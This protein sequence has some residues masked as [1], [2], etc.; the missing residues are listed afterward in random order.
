MRKGVSKSF[1]VLTVTAIALILGNI[2]TT[3]MPIVYA[4]EIEEINQTDNPIDT[5]ETDV[6]TSTDSDESDSNTNNSGNNDSS[7][8]DD[9]L[10]VNSSD[11]LLDVLDTFNEEEDSIADRDIEDNQ[12][13]TEDSMDNTDE[14]LEET[15]P[16]LT[17]IISPFSLSSSRSTEVDL[18]EISDL[19][20]LDN[21]LNNN[22]N[23]NPIKAKL[24][25]NIT[26]SI[27]VNEGKVLTLDLNGCTISS[28]STVL[29]VNG[30][31]VTITGNGKLESTGNYTVDI[32]AGKF[33]LESGTVSGNSFA[34]YIKGGE[35]NINGGTVET[36]SSSVDVHTIHINSGNLTVNGG[37]ISANGNEGSGALMMQGG[38]AKITGGSLYTKI[39]GGYGYAC[40]ATD[41]ASLTIS[42]GTFTL[43]APA[44]KS[45]CIGSSVSASVTGGSYSSNSGGIGIDV[46]PNTADSIGAWANAFYSRLGG[47]V[48]SDNT[49]YKE[50]IFVY[51]S[52]SV[53]V[54]NGT[55][56]GQETRE[57]TAESAYSF[58]SDGWSI[59]GDSTVYN[60]GS[61]YVP[62]NGQYTFSNK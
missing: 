55:W 1:T 43:D 35:A 39:T 41:T 32:S 22:T 24:S 20:S 9:N 57:L 34:I 6:N 60:S 44:G 4:E 38:N 11:E 10:D 16:L 13:D 51:T 49:F 19:T 15:E 8:A 47:G 31:T 42:G 53:S 21:A 40:Y 58:T 61:F 12:A 25:Q 18:G 33:V 46:T 26:G 23:N 29:S 3:Y 14:E 17:S 28:S 45:L 52:S 5:D 30:G 56:N 48:L 2:E 62:K 59:D 36:N 37:T 54:M 7:I 50:G 27:A